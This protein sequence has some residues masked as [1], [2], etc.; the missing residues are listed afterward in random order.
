MEIEKLKHVV[1]ELLTPEEYKTYIQALMT[2]EKVMA[3]SGINTSEGPVDVEKIPQKLK[4][5]YKQA[6]DFLEYVNRKQ[7][8]TKQ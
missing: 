1:K 2:H 8:E 5:E 4:N 6:V 3:Q 7:H